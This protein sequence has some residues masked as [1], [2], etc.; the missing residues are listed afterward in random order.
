MKKLQCE[1]CGG[2]LMMQDGIAVCESCGM[3]FSKD[4]VKKMVVELSGPI[5]IDGEVKVTGVD[6]ADTLYRR[7]KDAERI[8]ELGHAEKTYYDATK[9][10]PGDA[11][12]WLG[13][14]AVQ[15]KRK[16]EESKENGRINWRFEHS[17]GDPKWCDEIEKL[18]ERAQSLGGDT[19][20]VQRDLLWFRNQKELI[21]QKNKNQTRMDEF[22]RYWSLSNANFLNAHYPYDKKRALAFLLKLDSK[23]LDEELRKITG[24]FTLIDSF[25]KV[26]G[27]SL[28]I[29]YHH[30]GSS[31][32]TKSCEIKLPECM[33][34][35]GDIRP[36]FD[37]VTYKTGLILGRK[38]YS[39]ANDPNKDKGP[40]FDE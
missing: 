21:I 3:K 33:T 31:S 27:N 23:A 19:D 8:G 7:A 17:F 11:R 37:G 30:S 13:Y 4:E 34:I 29:K 36:L 10:Y 9:K 39:Y 14:A 2:S 22:I 24:D 40:T 25:E 5:Q 1:I 12:M 6:D 38:K 28:W 15:V 20:E 32:W 35:Q 16:L 26:H 18:Y